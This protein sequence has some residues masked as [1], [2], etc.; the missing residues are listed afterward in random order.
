MSTKFKSLNDF[1][2]NASESKKQRV[3]EKVIHEALIEQRELLAKAD[4]MRKEDLCY[5]NHKS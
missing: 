2:R 5:G 3:F 4:A 1:I